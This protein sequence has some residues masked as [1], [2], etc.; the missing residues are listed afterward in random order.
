MTCHND[1]AMKPQRKLGL[2]RYTEHM[3]ADSC[4]LRDIGNSSCL[5]LNAI[6]WYSLWLTLLIFGS[7]RRAI[8][9]SVIP[10]AADAFFTMV[11]LSSRIKPLFLPLPVSSSLVTL[12]EEELES[13]DTIAE[14][15]LASRFLAATSHE[16]IHNRRHVVRLKAIFP[17]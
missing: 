2:P 4:N 1:K 6:S 5:H 12:F 9:L 17:R 7:R 11:L 8:P 15:V 10:A 14:P 3:H 16:A 13:L